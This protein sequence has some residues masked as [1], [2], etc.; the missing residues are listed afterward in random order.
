MTVLCSEI[1]HCAK[2]QTVHAIDPT[3]GI[4][5][6]Y[7][8]FTPDGVTGVTGT[9]RIV[10]ENVYH[11]ID[12]HIT[13]NNVGPEFLIV[14]RPGGDPSEIIM[15]FN[16]QDSLRID[17]DHVL[18][19]YLG[20]WTVGLPQGYVYQQQ[21][22]TI[23]QVPW[24]ANWDH[25]AG[26]LQVKLELG[27]Y[28][29]ERPLIIL[30]SPGGDPLQAGGGGGSN[31]PPEWSTY[32]ATPGGDGMLGLDTDPQGHAYFTGY[33]TS[34]SVLPV[35]AG[36]QLYNA[37]GDLIVGRFNS[38]Y[39]IEAPGTWM[40]YFG[41]QGYEVGEAIAYDAV[42]ARVVVGGR[43]D[44]NSPAP[45]F[46]LAAN[47]DCFQNALGH[48]FLAFFDAGSGEAMYFTRIHPSPLSKSYLTDVD[49]DAAG[50][51]YFT[52]YSEVDGLD[53]ANPPGTADYFADGAP[54]LDGLYPYDA[55][56]GKLSTEADLTWS[57][58]L[59]GPRQE[60]GYAC[61]VD[62]ERNKLYVAGI[63]ESPNTATPDGSP[64]SETAE[65]PLVNGGGWFQYRLNGTSNSQFGFD[66]FI[67]CFDLNTLGMLWS[68][69][70]GGAG[71]DDAITDVTTDLAGNIYITGFTNTAYF[72]AGAPCSW[73][74]T[75][76]G[77]PNC[78][79]EGGYHQAAFGGGSYD[80]FIAKFDPQYALLSFTWVGGGLNEAHQTPIAYHRPRITNYHTV[81]QQGPI[82]LFAH[83]PSGNEGQYLDP[84]VP[85]LASPLY[86]QQDWHHDA[87]QG[88]PEETDTYIAIFST[89][90]A[91]LAATYF[92]GK[93]SDQAAA[94]AATASRVYIAGRT[95]APVLFPLGV[96][97]MPPP[98][99][100]YINWN[101]EC[102]NAI[103]DG[104]IAQI[105]YDIVSVGV[106]EPGPMAPRKGLSIAPN[107]S[108]GLVRVTLP[109]AQG[110]LSVLEV[111]GRVVHLLRT[112]STVTH[113][114]LG[115]LPGGLYTL[116]FT[117]DGV[118]ASGRLVKY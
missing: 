26:S 4:R 29:P 42:H 38:N 117:A 113:L 32:V 75:Q 88:T 3:S 91:Q 16:G 67:T 22:T 92:G 83:T 65:F 45:L 56:V 50:N 89:T 2:R 7:E 96:P 13:S 115:A 73:T 86:Y 46:P 99:A 33:S 37:G 17:V 110:I 21:D 27:D 90:G 104:Y 62:R 102:G 68:S 80:H 74:N 93:G 55:F 112:G 81:E 47:P 39:E 43:N 63:T 100:P 64:G 15:K 118:S 70:F 54:E 94:V 78:N 98:L 48:C 20:G 87:G 12:F 30:F 51:A 103:H 105:Q 1:R 108:T 114:D 44:Y 76:S 107:P 24:L 10:M 49:V 60:Y 19:T 58:A 25:N 116:L 36:L 61:H 18:K 28:N 69:Y 111:S 6:F 82:V 11:N 23:I 35:T 77:M 66:G 85:M 8:R 97:W 40:T 79:T 52:G 109:K 14:V 57:I 95:L 31:D 9:R 84:P 101:A 72:S 53:L 71:T 41:A 59:G 5:N 106:A 34:N